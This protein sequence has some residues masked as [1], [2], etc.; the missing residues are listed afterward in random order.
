MANCVQCGRRLPGLTFGKK[1]CPWCKQHEAAQRGEVDEDAKQHVMPTPWVRRRESSITLTHVLFG[2]NLAVFLAMLAASADPFAF[3]HPLQEFS[4]QVSIHFGAN[5]GPLTLSGDWWRLLT[6]MFLHGSVLHIAFNMWCLWD[7]GQLC[8][9]LYGRW[10]YAAIYGITGIAAG[11]ASV[12]WNPEVWSVG[13]SG[14]IFGLAG[15]LLAS[16]YLGEF[17]LPRVAIQGTLRSLLFFV[18][19]NVLFGSMFPGI[20]NACHIGGLISGLILGA[21]IA[22][23]APQ[24][25]APLRRVSVLA[26]VALVVAGGAWGVQHWRYPMRFARSSIYSQRNIDRMI[27]DLQKKV[28]R[29]PKDPSAHYDLARA[30]FTQ[31][32]VTEATSELKRVLELQP[33]NTRARLELGA[34][35]LSESQFKEAQPEF[36]QLL[37]QEPNNA[38]AH[39]GLGMALA[40]QQN[41]EAAIH[42]YK[43]ALQLDPQAAGV[44]YKLGLSQAQLKQYDDAIG[45]YLKERQNSGDD[46]VL[47]TALAD[48]YQ[49]KGM[50]QQADNARA[51]AA[52]LRGAQHQ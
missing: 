32:Q 33:Q 14:A 19:F 34:A 44:Y 46:A 16:F 6:Y 10:T 35:Y 38:D 37:A 1:I 12:A 49:A 47:E 30:Y 29:S 20:D 18:G 22:R 41:H 40:G 24:D 3:I 26:A 8:E 17:S 4:P 45:S 13:A 7:L 21:L 15:A 51:E 11:V 43:A 52:Q 25:D 28:Q 2:A 9:S 27:A 23:V 36:V 31:G 39:V 50:T 42:E 48:A 5:Y